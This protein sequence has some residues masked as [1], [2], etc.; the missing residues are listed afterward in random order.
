MPI[1]RLASKAFLLLGLIAGSIL[2]PA[3]LLGILLHRYVSTPAIDTRDRRHAFVAFTLLGLVTIGVLWWLGDS[4]GLFFRQTIQAISL[5]A[6]T[7]SILSLTLFWSVTV[8]MAPVVAWLIQMV[9][10]LRA[11]YGDLVLPDKTV[12][13]PLMITPDASGQ[14]KTTEVI[15][16]GPTRIGGEAPAV[17][18]STG[19]GSRSHTQAL[20][21]Y[22]GGAS[23]VSRIPERINGQAVIGHPQ[24]GDLDWIEAGWFV[25]PE[26][27]LREHGII[28]GGSG[29]GK[30][31]FALRLASVAR[32]VY[33]WR[34][35]YLDAKAD[36]DT[37]ISFVTEM[38]R[39]GT[40]VRVFPQE[41]LDG[42]R[43]TSTAIRNRILQLLTYSES[44]YKD[45]ARL[46]LGLA[47]DAPGGVPRSHTAFLDRLDKERLEQLYHAN[48]KRKLLE[49]I[50]AAH[51][52]GTRLRYE[53][54][55][56]SAQTLLDGSW[57]WEDTQAAYIALDSLGQ[58]D[59][60]QA[61][62]RFLIEDFGHFMKHRKPPHERVLLILEEFS[63]LAEHVD[64]TNLF[65]RIRSAGG[66]V[67]V[68][69]QGDK[70]LG[71]QTA[72]LIQACANLIVFQGSDPETLIQQAGT[73]LIPE[74]SLHRSLEDPR[75]LPRGLSDHAS[76]GQR[77]VTLRMQERS[78][79]HAN[80]VQQLHKG[81]GFFI[82]KGQTQ[83]VQVE[84][85]SHSEEMRHSAQAMLQAL[86]QVQTVD[87]HEQT[88][89]QQAPTHTVQSMPASSHAPNEGQQ[90]DAGRQE[91]QST[92]HSKQPLPVK[93]TGRSLFDA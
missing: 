3:M 34:V 67:F 83:K 66:S 79:I 68:I 49:H 64:V 51:F 71:T 57:S 40:S 77:S 22:Y 1:T 27:A 13:R 86:D 81:E 41:P 25:F 2:L 53:S 52:S 20:T 36:R 30:T 59:D 63:A 31:S 29:S 69:T 18:L 80:E 55:F 12:R 21:Y 37:A 61:L 42:W 19:T 35:Y 48:S 24:G 78:K 91:A 26:E 85:L 62:G 82:F 56:T 9:I 38:R 32:S 39:L 17:S 7:A 11:T 46:L 76:E 89:K 90:K 23:T 6:W 4:P 45:G 60:T 73:R 72:K 5:H 10:L 14:G 47:L 43:G 70:S 93:K 92:S 87:R 65:Q 54:F 28:S 50:Q 8:P 84:A 16:S 58:Q 33:G 88:T 75:P 74:R 15:L 44:F